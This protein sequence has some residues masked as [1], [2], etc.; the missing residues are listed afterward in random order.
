MSWAYGARP[1]LAEVSQAGRSKPGPAAMPTCSCGRPSLTSEIPASSSSVSPGSV[2]DGGAEPADG[3]V[4]ARERG[5][6]RLGIGAVV[7]A[8]ARPGR[9]RR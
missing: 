4:D 3:L 9:R 1:V 7:G 2:G 5:R 6:P 8:L